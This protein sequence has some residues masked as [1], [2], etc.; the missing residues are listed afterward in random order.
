[1][2]LPEEHRF[3]IPPD[4][5]CE[6]LSPQ[7]ARNDRIRK[8]RIFAWHEVQYAWLIDP[9]LKTLEVFGLESGRWFL[10]DAFAENEKERAEPFKEI[11]INLADLWIG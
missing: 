4:W 8:M 7:T 3:T 2:T 9:I 10:M 6:I 5:V 11:E 1:M